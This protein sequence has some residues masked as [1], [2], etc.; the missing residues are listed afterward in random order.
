MTEEIKTQIRNILSDFREN[1]KFHKDHS[2]SNT[3]TRLVEPLFKALGWNEKDWIKQEQI[4]RGQKQGRADYVFKINDKIVFVLEVKKVGIQLEKEA[5]RQVISYALSR[6]IP[7]AI[8]TN[9]ECMNIFCVE[10]ED[11]INNKFRVFNSPEDYINNINDLLFLSKESFAQNSILKKAESEGRLKKRVTINKPLLEDF[12]NV[13]RLISNDIEHTYPGKY[14]PNEKDEIVQRIIDRLIF[15]RRCEDTG[16]NPDNITLEEINHLPDNKA[17]LR[18]KEIFSK[19][20]SV[21]NSGL[22]AINQDND[23]DTIKIDGTIIKKLLGHLYESTDKTYI[24]DFDWIDADVL[25]QVY[26]QYLGI[27]LAQTK[28]GKAQLK[29][30]QAH[31]KEQGIYYTPTYVVDY[32][33]KNTL[34]ELLKNKKLNTKNIKILDP[35]CGSGSFLIKAFDYLN[36][37]LGNT[38]EAKQHKL[39]SQGGYS[40]KTDILKNHVYGVDLDNKAV[41]ITKLNLLLKAAEKNRKLPEEIDLH[42][43]HGN[44]LID[45]ATIAGLN[46]FKW[47]GEFEEDSFDVVI[48]N[49]PYV[50]AREKISDIEKGYYAKNYESAK[51]QL[52]TYVLFIEKAVKLLKEEGRLGF[53]VPDAWLRV[54]SVS[55]LRKFL[56]ENTFLEKIIQIRGETFDGVGVES[57]IFILRK[58]RKIGTTLICKDFSTL[59]YYEASKKEWLVN[60]NYE[61][62]LF[63][64]KHVKNILEKIE[65]K[66]KPLDEVC[67]I[68]AGLQAYEKGKGKPKQSGADV[69]NPFK[70]LEG[71]DIGRY[72]YQ[73]NNK[74]LRYGECLA[75]P[76]T[77]NL[78]NSP[79]IL[80]REIPGK[81][82]YTII[83]HYMSDTFLNNRSIINILKK[84]EDLDLKFVV[85]ILNSKLISFYHLNKSVKAQRDLFP[86]VTLNDLRRFPIKIANKDEQKKIISLVEKS[87]DFNA[88]LIQ[89]NNK[90]TLETSKLQEEL[91]SINN[92]IDDLAYKLYGI[93]DTER[94]VIE[95]S[96]K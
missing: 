67:D 23:C 24:Y 72:N 11:A 59:S 18:L 22:F 53:I 70:Y 88:T 28:T 15:V 25:G 65:T 80:V 90:K 57:S 16:I 56:L 85:G 40:I 48:G 94:K 8:S 60:K 4:H 3:E 49:P 5:N 45:D 58:T 92:Q 50:F 68:K 95:D 21:Y 83:A 34:G 51:Y 75:A 76:R 36:K 89:K 96:L 31:R 47:I 19:Y 74:W 77:F 41:E 2:E 46:A 55:N 78:F 66:T 61:I 91:A 39:D 38:E 42:I 33:V 1:Y 17:Y 62:D 79:R 54:E 82:P 52:N 6:R 73:W 44:S 81:P 26:E 9:F 84:D 30:G 27:I 64:D 43:R 10:Q 20:N 7:F 35:A 37:E 93:T 13:R 29:D 14:A 63:S 69:K 12:M 32:I 71:K 86:K 87:L